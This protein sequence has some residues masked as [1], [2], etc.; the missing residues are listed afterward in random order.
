[1]CI[2]LARREQGRFV[3]RDPL[4]SAGL[5][6]KRRR[7]GGPRRIA[8]NELR[9][10]R[11]NASNSHQLG[12][13]KTTRRNAKR[14]ERKVT[15]KSHM[16]EQ[17]STA[18]THSLTLPF[19]PAQTDDTACQRIPQQVVQ[20]AEARCAG[21]GVFCCLI[22]TRTRAARYST[23]RYSARFAYALIF[24]ASAARR[25]RRQQTSTTV[26]T[27]AERQ[28]AKPEPGGRGCMIGPWDALC[29][30]RR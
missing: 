24:S 8:R 11:N 4:A 6:S 21:V 19:A 9:S 10:N 5:A 7:E 18:H 25:R 16:K 22:L 2:S 29:S 13:K 20:L 28:S 30:V 12:A 27:S 1:M 3:N 26:R 14:S 23:V 17:H 15:Y